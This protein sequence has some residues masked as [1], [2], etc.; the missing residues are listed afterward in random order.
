MIRYLSRADFA[1][2][3]GVKPDSLGRYKLPDPDAMIGDIRGWLPQTVDEWNRARPGKGAG[4]GRKPHSAA[5]HGKHPRQG[6]ER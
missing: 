3:L 2:R 5:P 4:A 1:E 6:H